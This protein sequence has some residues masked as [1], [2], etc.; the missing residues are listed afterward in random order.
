MKQEFTQEMKN[1]I[2][3]IVRDVHTAVPGKIVTFDP[4]KCEATIQPTAKYR[5]PDG[6]LID[7]PKIFEVPVYFPQSTAQK[8]SI[9]HH[10]KPGDEC[11]IL[12]LEQALDQWRTG[13]ESATELHFDMQNAVAIPGLFARPNP[14]VRR[15]H[16]N[17]SII[18]QREGSFIEMFG[19][20]AMDIHAMGAM[21][22]TSATSITMI[23]PTVDIN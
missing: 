9:V 10:I 16:D 8:V 1:L 11:L 19:S 17:E 6:G 15:A 21:T 4:D 23:A 5:K 22:I 7:Y 3:D 12:M 20:G 18:I 13:A 14:L 2:L